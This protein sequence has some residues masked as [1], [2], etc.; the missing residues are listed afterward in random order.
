[1]LPVYILNHM[2]Q[3]ISL[4]VLGVFTATNNSD[5][6]LLIIYI[7]QLFCFGY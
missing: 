1:M 6:T 4:S 2:E 7:Q 5:Y 3:T